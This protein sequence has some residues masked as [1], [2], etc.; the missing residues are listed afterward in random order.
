[1]PEVE[2]VAFRP[3]GK[4][5][6]VAASS[7]V[8]LVDTATGYE[9]MRLPGQESPCS[10]AFSPDGQTLLSGGWDK[11]VRLWETATGKEVVRVEGL[12]YVNAV[13]FAPDG[14]RVAAATGWLDGVIHIFDV[15]A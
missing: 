3:D 9:L 7:A 14:R 6:A 1:G 4:V 8:S 11:A 2:A 13:A 5:A 15:P 10:L 12:D